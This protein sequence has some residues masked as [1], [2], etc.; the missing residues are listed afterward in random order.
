[1]PGLQKGRVLL[2]VE[3]Q[4]P[5]AGGSESKTRASRE[6]HGGIGEKREATREDLSEQIADALHSVQT[7]PALLQRKTP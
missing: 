4:N 7:A 5:P 3:R 1:M 6:I 2:R